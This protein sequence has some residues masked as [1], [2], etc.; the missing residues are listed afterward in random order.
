MHKLKNII[1]TYGYIILLAFAFESTAQI[2][3]GDLAAAH[4]EL[5]GIRNCTKCHDLGNKVPNSKCL[6]CHKEIN[7]LLS[8][9]RGFHASKDAKSKQCIDCH[10]DH[11]GRKFEMT[12][13]DQDNF[14]HDLTSYKLEDKHAEIDC[15]DCHQPSHIADIDLKFRDQTFLG[16][17]K[18]CLS[19][20]DDFHQKSLSNDCINCHNFEAFRP[21]PKFD[22]AK[23]DFVLKGS[24][25]DVDCKKCHPIITKNGSDFQQFTGMLFAD[26]R[27]CHEDPHKGHLPT[28]CSSCHDENSFQ[29]LTATKKFNHNQTSFKLNGSHKEV[30]CFSCHEQTNNAASIFQDKLNINTTECASCHTDVHEGKLGTNCVSCHSEE[31][32][33]S[34]KTPE[35]FDHG[36]T[37]FPLQGLHTTVDCKKCHLDNYLEPIDFTSCKNCHEDFHEGQFIRDNQISPDCIE[38]H[39]LSEGFSYTLFSFDDH[40]STDFPLAGAHMATPCFACHVSEEKWEFKNMGNE[41]IDCHEDFHEGYLSVDYYPKKECNN[42]HNSDSWSEVKFDHSLTG[43]NLEGTHSTTDC[44]TCHFDDSSAPENG[45]VQ[46]FA[47]LT[48]DCIQCHDNIHGNEFEQKGITDCTRCHGFNDWS[49]ERFD[50]NQSAFPLEGKHAEIECKACHKSYEEQGKIIVKYKMEKFQCIDCHS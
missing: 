27:N 26:C 10:S 14:N 6:D 4:S 32:F 34:S 3:P 16:L 35:Q 9:K 5:E 30:A 15:R 49:A 41:C 19:C 40:Q 33:K 48:N 23:A 17:Q 36:L 50:H 24:H 2:S 12:R 20:H 25:I 21:A 28:K 29:N 31:S 37:D 43:W 39:S 45:S 18:E 38:C 47:Q 7:E 44:R 8:E 42:C 22:H 13:F 1:K 11:H 46:L